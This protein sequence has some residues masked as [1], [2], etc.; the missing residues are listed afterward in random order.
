MSL[1]MNRSKSA[2]S[3]GDASST[4]TTTVRLIPNPNPPPH[5][6]YSF[7]PAAARDFIERLLA[8]S[9]SIR[10]PPS[11]ALEHPWLV[12]FEALATHVPLGN[13]P[14]ADTHYSQSQ[15][16]N[17]QGSSQEADA[18]AA[19][20]LADASMREAPPPGSQPL[21][22]L[23]GAFPQSQPLQRRADVLL[24]QS[25]QERGVDDLV[26]SDGEDEDDGLSAGPST[27]RGKKRKALDF[28]G[29]LT[30]MEEEE[31][32]EED[33]EEDPNA[34]AV[35][36][37]KPAARVGAGRG[38]GAA[39]GRPPRKMVVARG[40]KRASVPASATRRSERLGNGTPAKGK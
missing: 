28:E 21:P 35:S 6:N 4:A 31:E 23:P 11:A 12:A 13:L 15:L 29:S 10:M 9:P 17:S 24:A 16:H 27:V 26:Y 30:P 25:Q 1:Y 34:M 36:P 39:S 33:G 7:L 3:T 22:G 19:M 5:T 20:E 32:E 8:Y 2:R 18:D 40:P 37:R 38:R 14:P